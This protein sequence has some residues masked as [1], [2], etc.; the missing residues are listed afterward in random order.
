MKEEDAISVSA[1]LLAHS[2]NVNKERHESSL[3][4]SDCKPH[5]ELIR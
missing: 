2:R 3:L 5:V 1:I 4:A